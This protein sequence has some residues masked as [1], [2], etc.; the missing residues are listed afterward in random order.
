Y[1][2]RFV[3]HYGSISTPLIA[4]L[5]KDSF[6]WSEDATKSFEQLKAAMCTTSVLATLD[7]SKTFIVECDASKVCMGAVPMQE[8]HPIAFL[9]HQFK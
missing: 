4:L 8:G 7:F 9:S 1:Y 3:R 5:K 6:H 2:R